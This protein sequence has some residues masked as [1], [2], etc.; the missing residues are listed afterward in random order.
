[1]PYGDLSHAKAR[2]YLA[3]EAL[4][5]FFF[6]AGTVFLRSLSVWKAISK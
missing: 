3:L 1:M 6:E 2:E 4:F 5:L